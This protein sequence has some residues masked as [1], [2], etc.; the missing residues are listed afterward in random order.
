MILSIRHNLNSQGKRLYWI[1]NEL[2]ITPY[3][4]AKELGYKTP[5]TIYHVLNGIKNINNS[6][7]LRISSFNSEINTDW[8]ISGWGDPFNYK[9][10]RHEFVDDNGKIFYP[11]RLNFDLIKKLAIAFSELIF[12]NPQEESYIV[13]VRKCAIEG[14][15]FLFSTFKFYQEEKRFDKFYT[16]ILQPDWRVSC[17]FDF[18][19][20]EDFSR[21]G[22]NL[23]D[24]MKNLPLS[25]EQQFE[26]CIYSFLKKINENNSDEDPYF[27]DDP[28]F[29]FEHKGNFVELFRTNSR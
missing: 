19:R 10:Y 11:A 2:N 27:I 9:L 21:R 18:W 24:L 6:L 28:L 12:F 8:I 3:R 20:V 4:F 29:G 5:D 26:N 25:V 7:S 16:V 23:L 22:Q 14:L 13:D 15:E 17:F 1:I